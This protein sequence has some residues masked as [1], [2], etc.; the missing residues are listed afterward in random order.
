MASFATTHV[1]PYEALTKA[2]AANPLTGKSTL[3]TGAGRGVGEHI[4]R[5]LAAAGVSRI[6]LVGRD[7][8]RINKAKKNFQETFPRTVFGAFS[9]DITD[10]AKIASVFKEFGAPDIVIN[11]A[12]HFP[13]EGPFIKEDLKSWW[14]GFE[15]NILGTAIVTQQFLRAK[16]VGK[17]ATVISLSTIGI[18]MRFP[19]PGWSGYAT[20]K[21]GQ[22]RVFEL[23]RFEH[24]EVWVINVHPGSVETDGYAKTGLPA[25]PNGMTDG[26][27]T[28]QFFAWL[29]S[30]EA[31][32]LRGRF[33]WADSDVDELKAKKE[34][35][36]SDDLLL[37]TIDG[38]VKGF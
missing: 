25:P 38:L 2:V 18:H 32:F 9:A 20:S 24:P 26:K 4:T 27:L 6:A 21:M 34:Q 37:T 16:P 10:E 33:V 15:V 28:G 3:I 31:E 19:L 13:D 1:K 12:G 5:E 14:K 30:D 22:A 23:L 29:A 36:I 17:S 7:L 11:S 8:E 35:I